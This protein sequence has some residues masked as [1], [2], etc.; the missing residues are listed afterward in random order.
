MSYSDLFQ[1]FNSIIRSQKESGI[2]NKISNIYFMDSDI[3]LG[4]GGTIKEFN[5]NFDLLM[6][7]IFYDFTTLED[8]IY[9]ARNQY[10]ESLFSIKDMFIKEFSI[11]LNSDY[12][13]STDLQNNVNNYIINSFEENSKLQYYF[14]DTTM[15]DGSVGMRNW[16]LTLPMMGVC[17]AVYPYAIKDDK[18]NIHKIIHHDGHASDV[19]FQPNEKRKNL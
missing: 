6:S 17:P 15:F 1:H 19:Y 12:T 14:G 11:L 16:I 7:A 5:G 3:N 2:D 13:S 18:L 9:F 10:N 8:L 4:L